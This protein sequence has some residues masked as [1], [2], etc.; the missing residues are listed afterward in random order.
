M[1]DALGVSAGSTVLYP[2]TRTFW[3]E[4]AFEKKDIGFLRDPTTIC[5]YH[6]KKT[7]NINDIKKKC[8]FFKLNFPQHES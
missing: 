2:R 7:F 6:K 1:R 5:S 3:K 4:T 8:L